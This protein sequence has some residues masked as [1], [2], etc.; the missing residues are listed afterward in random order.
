MQIAHKVNAS[1]RIRALVMGAFVVAAAPALSQSAQPAS[2]PA[3]PPAYTTQTTTQTTTQPTPAPVTTPTRGVRAPSGGVRAPS[4]GVRAPSGGVRAPSGGVRAPGGGVRAPG[5]GVRPPVTPTPGGTPMPPGN[6]TDPVDP[7]DP[8][9]PPGNGCDHGTDCTCYWY[10]GW[11]WYGWGFGWGHSWYS[12]PWYYR[13][14]VYG[15]RNRELEVRTTPEPEPLT[16]IE[17]ARVL[18]EAGR[19]EQAVTWYRSHLN[20]NPGDAAA[21]RELAVALLESG[22]F[23]DASA[24]MGYIYDRVPGL[25]NEPLQESL[26][27]YSPL[28][29]RQSVTDAVRYANRSPSGNAWLMVAVLMQAQGKDDAALRMVERATDQGLSPSIADRMRVQLARQ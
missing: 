13:D 5:A 29:L 27:G 8:T 22:R 12:I 15:P 17:T 2:P 10:P 23:L 21:T 4:G 11:G 14:G 6:P 25:A 19:S 3:A 9:D 24:M 1:F 7:T 20:D 28:R 18:M 16:P 26:W